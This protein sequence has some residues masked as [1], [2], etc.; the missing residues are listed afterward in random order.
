MR[1]L[2]LECQQ[3]GNVLAARQARPREVKMPW[4]VDPTLRGEEQ[5]PVVRR[6]DEN[7]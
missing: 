2:G 1:S 4:P 5:D 6:A 7:G 3:V